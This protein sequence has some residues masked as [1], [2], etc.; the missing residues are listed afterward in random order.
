MRR[1]RDAKTGGIEKYKARLNVYGSSQNE[2]G[3]ALQHDLLARGL[4]ELRQG[5]PDSNYSTRLAYQAN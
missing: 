5:A 2:E 4:L 1:K 3:R